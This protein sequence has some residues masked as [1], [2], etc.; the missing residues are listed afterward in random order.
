MGDAPLERAVR[1]IER[2]VMRFG[3]A[4]REHIRGPHIVTSVQLDAA[5]AGA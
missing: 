3:Q 1:A 4:E 2:D 5:A